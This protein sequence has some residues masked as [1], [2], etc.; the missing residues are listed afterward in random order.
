LR[1]ENEKS[2]KIGVILSD[3]GKKFENIKFDDFALK[4]GIYINTPLNT[5]HNKIEL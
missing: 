1:I 4:R 3:H 5:F 2:L